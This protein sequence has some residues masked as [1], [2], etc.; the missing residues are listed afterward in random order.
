MKKEVAIGAIVVQDP[1]LSADEDPIQDLGAI[2]EAIDIDITADLDL[3]VLDTEDIQEAEVEAVHTHQDIHILL[4]I[5]PVDLIMTTI[6]DMVV[7]VVVAAKDV[8]QGTI[9]PLCQVEEGILGTGTIQNLV[10]A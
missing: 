5:A 10:D 4:N 3:T 7:A 8:I 1:I 9:D 6:I 2:P